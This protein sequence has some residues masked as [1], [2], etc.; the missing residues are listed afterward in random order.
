MFFL[1]FSE[2][3]HTSF[4]L[5]HYFLFFIFYGSLLFS[6]SLLSE[7]S[8]FLLIRFVFVVHLENLFILL[9]QQVLALFLFFLELL[10]EILIVLLPETERV[11]AF[12]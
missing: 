11:L 2:E 5:P 1:L 9:A 8:S 10:D 12:D 4:L 6:Q 3:L 7:V